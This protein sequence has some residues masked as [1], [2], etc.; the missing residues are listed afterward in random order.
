MEIDQNNLK[1]G[2]LETLKIAV[3]GWGNLFRAMIFIVIISTILGAGYLL[4]KYDFDK[5]FEQIDYQSNRTKINEDKFDEVAR[6][7]IKRLEVKYVLFAKMEPEVG[8]RTVLRVYLEDGSRESVLEN[9]VTNL[10]TTGKDTREFLSA[11]AGG[12]VPCGL[13]KQPSNIVQLYFMDKGVTT[14]CGVSIPPENA[15]FVGYIT[16]GFAD[17]KFAFD[18]KLKVENLLRLASEMMSK[19]SIK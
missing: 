1:E 7:L 10:N 16:V 5:V 3:S 12:E 15:E 19:R 4:Y 17:D 18:N 11:L 6:F 8:K 13:I 2:W 9:T 14:I